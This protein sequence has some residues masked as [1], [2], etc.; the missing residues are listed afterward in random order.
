MKRPR[1]DQYKY[2]H[3]R[4]EDLDVIDNDVNNETETSC[5]DC[6]HDQDKGKGLRMNV[7]TSHKDK[8]RYSC[9]KRDSINGSKD[10]Q[11]SHKKYDESYLPMKG[12][13]GKILFECKLCKT[14]FSS[15]KAVKQH[16]RM[17]HG[18][19]HGYPCQDSERFYYID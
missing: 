11:E 17:K 10:N 7:Q 19:Q 6:Q 12:S 5:D 14:S 2:L 3:I 4:S 18:A 15:Q 16:G 13:D 8:N 1:K 9:D